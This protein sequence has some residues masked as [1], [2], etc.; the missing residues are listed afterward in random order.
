MSVKYEYNSAIRDY[1]LFK[2]GHPK[3][4]LRVARFFLGHD[5]FMQIRPPRFATF[6]AFLADKPHPKLFTNFVGE[7]CGLIIL[8]YIWYVIIKY[9]ELTQNDP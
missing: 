3:E 7:K 9:T 5:H 6:S 1:L 8:E 2:P 4:Y